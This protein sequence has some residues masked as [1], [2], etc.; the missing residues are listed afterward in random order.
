M[1]RRLLLA[2][3]GVLALATQLWP[4]EASA[5]P[6]FARK[7]NVGCTTCHVAF[8]VLNATG[9]RF[10]EAGYRMAN[11]K[12][13]VDEKQEPN[14]TITTGLVLG[15]VFPL[16][17]RLRGSPFIDVKDEPISSRPISEASLISAGNW[18]TKGSVFL[19]V[20]AADE[21]DWKPQV[22]A[23]AGYHPI[24]FA[25][26]VLGNRGP[27]PVDPFNTFRD[28]ISATDRNSFARIAGDDIGIP[29]VDFYGWTP[30]I[31]YAAAL[32]AG[33][34]NTLGLR[35]RTF[36]GRLAY[37]LQQGSIFGAFVQGGRRGTT[38][39]EPDYWQ[40]GADA[41]AL[42]RN[43]SV[44]ALFA[45]LREP[46]DPDLL[47]KDFTGF[48]EAFYAFDLGAPGSLIPLARLEYDTFSNRDRSEL[49]LLVGLF[50][51]F[52]MNARGGVEWKTDLIPAV[53]GQRQW[54]FL[55]SVDLAY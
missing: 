37:Q 6:A 18:W 55:V 20:G 9:R 25:N 27:F 23:T 51:D 38:P 11:V 5:I 31:Y 34:D 12:G 16:S 24:R 32:S 2:L 46:R 35:P 30:S 17:A 50:Y 4:R 28:T 48:F 15:P 19:E 7:Y 42:W 39:A 21:D 44:T 49:A 26:L 47:D 14:R 1:N 54:R 13:E 40:V 52:V 29:T 10:R 36:F 53:S 33:L 41:N 45:Y 22:A 3:A 43:L 8:P